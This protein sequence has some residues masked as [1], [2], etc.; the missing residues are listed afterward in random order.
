[1]ADE[2]A[3]SADQQAQRFEDLATWKSKRYLSAAYGALVLCGGCALMGAIGNNP[4]FLALAVGN[5]MV[6]AMTFDLHFRYKI[7]LE[8]RILEDRIL[9]LE[10]RLETLEN[11]E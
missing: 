4:H 11:V 6:C 3:T 10:T 7:R 2:M 9:A 5:A 8:T 1:M